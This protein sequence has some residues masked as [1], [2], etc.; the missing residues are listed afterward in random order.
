MNMPRWYDIALAFTQHI[1]THGLIRSYWNHCDFECKGGGFM[2]QKTFAFED[3]RD[4]H[5][6]RHRTT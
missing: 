5:R 6:H 2:T 3:S 4:C 1:G